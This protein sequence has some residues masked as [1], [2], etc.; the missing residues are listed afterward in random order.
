MKIAKRLLLSLC[1]IS[2]LIAVACGETNTTT[3][4]LSADKVTVS[5]GETVTLT[6][7]VSDS[8]TETTANGATFEIIS[9]S[10]SCTLS[11]N[12]LTISQTATDKAVIKVVAKLDGKTSNTVEI[13]V[14]VPLETITISANESNVLAG[15]SIILTK[16]LTPSGLDKQVEWKIVEGQNYCAISGDILI[17]NTTAPTGAKIK[18]KAVSGSIESNE[19]TFTVGYLLEKIELSVVGSTNIQN[20]NSRPLVATLT[21]ANASDVEIDW[22]FVEGQD[23]CT[24]ANNVITISDTAPI[25]SIIK[26]KAVSGTIESNVIT[27]TVGTPIE[28][29][30]ITQIG[31]LE[32]V[33]GSTVGLSA[34]VTPANASTS[35]VQWEISEGEDYAQIIDK[36]LVVNQDAPTGATIKVKAVSGSIESNELTF[37]VLATQEE[38]NAS[39]LMLSLS[40]DELTLDKFGTSSPT[41]EVEIF[42]FNFEQITDRNV[43]FEILSGSEF[44]GIEADGYNCSFTALGHGKATIKVGIEGTEIEETAEINVIVPPTAI[45]LPEVFK[46]RNKLSYSFSKKDPR[47]SS[48]AELSFVASALGDNVCQDVSYSFKHEDGET[49]DQVAVWKDGKITFNK[50]GKTT[51]TVLSNSGSRVETTASYTFDVNEGYNVSTYDELNELVRSS[52]YTGQIINLVVLEKPVA[53]FGDHTY[54]YDLVPS[55]VL[56]YAKDDQ[57]L[58]NITNSALNIQ[59]VNKNFYLNGNNHKFDLSQVKAPTQKEIDDYEQLGRNFSNPASII[60]VLPW[61]SDSNEVLRNTHSVNV[62]NVEFVG[63]CPIDYDGDIDGK[64]PSGS[65]GSGFTIGS[66]DKHESIYYIDVENVT[67]SA[68]YSGLRFDRVVNNGTAKNIHVYNCFSNGIETA[69]SIMTFDNIH[70]GKCGAA[71]IEFTPEKADKA[72]INHDQNQ[73]ITFIGDFKVENYNNGETKYLQ[74][75]NFNGITVPQVINMTMLQYDETQSSHIQNEKG[76]YVFVSFIF[77]DLSALPP[78]HNPSVVIYPEFQQGGIIDAKDLPTDGSDTTHQYIKFDILLTLPDMGN[79]TITIGQA[80]VY[81]HHYAG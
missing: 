24:I 40:D 32:V 14:S 1:L 16:T 5:R 8:K 52:A 56:D 41:L 28:E 55:V 12:K 77:E 38:I 46:E 67:V 44:V 39:K 58:E 51:V 4:S 57:P 21:P 72:G 26:L 42:N 33:K 3:L 15:N 25:G 19:L 45:N 73:T 71:G 31:S 59:V 75:Y 7:K 29:I 60:E 78:P 20:G 27:I 9:G 34:S 23:Y 54:G 53:K 79:Q 50:T 2:L 68:C 36:T 30:T 35:A 47:N 70:I 61:S 66:R 63:N 48:P 13:T 6:A 17:V 74:N 69:A 80:I 62:Y 64:R 43:T 22:T 81:N 11:E 65:I 76:E 10:D 18:V 37:T 49:G